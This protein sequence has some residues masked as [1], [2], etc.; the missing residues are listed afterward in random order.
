MSPVK[1][2]RTRLARRITAIRP[3]PKT[4]SLRRSIVERLS[5]KHDSLPPGVTPFVVLATERSG[6][7]LMMD[8]LSSRWSTIRSDGEI[9]NPHVRR[10][11]R[12]DEVIAG[13]YFADT[14][15]RFVGSKVIKRQVLDEDLCSLLSIPGMRVV[16]L[17]RDNL[18][19]QFV[20]L[21][22]AH[23]DMIWR[24]PAGFPRSDASVRAVHVEL[25]EL[26]SFEERMKNS[27]ATFADVTVGI[28]TCH[29]TYEAM[30]DDLDLE[31]RRI[32]DFLGAGEPDRLVPPRLRHQNP[33]PLSQLISNVDQLRADLV[34]AGHDHLVR[35]LD[36]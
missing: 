28:P 29:S 3:V 5:I 20:S 16:V 25:D 31:I 19:R 9:F 12:L 10:G 24:Q 17:K 36:A 35:M 23:K 30:M 21:E 13:T 4:E 32:G 1:H 27:Y 11:R 7:S 34:S 22:I 2:M 8:L 18:V 14:G 15:H 6:S 26:L 33:E